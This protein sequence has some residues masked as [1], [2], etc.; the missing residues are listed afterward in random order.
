MADA[1][2]LAGVCSIFSVSLFG[3]AWAAAIRIRLTKPDNDERRND[4]TEQK[5]ARRVTY[6]GGVAFGI[7]AIV[8]LVIAEF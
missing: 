6:W 7:L 3:M 8:F 5:R 1:I 2:I 4:I